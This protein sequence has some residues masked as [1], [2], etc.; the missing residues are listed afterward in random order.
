MRA[1]PVVLV[2]FDVR[3]NRS[4]LVGIMRDLYH[5]LPPHGLM[6]HH[7][8]D[9]FHTAGQGAINAEELIELIEFIGRHRILGA[10]EWFVL[11]DAGELRSGDTCIT[12]DDGLRCQYDVAA[13]VLRKYGIKAFFFVNT[14][15]S[16]S[17]GYRLEF[18]R[19]FRTVAFSKVDEFYRAFMAIVYS[20]EYGEKVRE[21]LC[22]FSPS[23]Y[24]KD[25]PFYTEGDRVFRYLRDDVLGPTSYFSL[26]DTMAASYGYVCDNAMKSRLWMGKEQLRNLSREGHIIGLHSHTHP[27]ALKRLSS[28]DQKFEYLCNSN[29]L[30]DILCK[31]PVCMS[32]PCNSYSD[33]TLDILRNLGIR[34]GFRANMVDGYG[35][36]LEY[37]RE[38]HANLLKEMKG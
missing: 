5:K 37:R 15:V 8:H 16:T 28:H 25:S 33:E 30:A 14:G 32:H 11:H 18:Y 17:D 24:L 34:L 12:F 4:V 35:S 13:P 10:E 20:S 29:A 36:G 2:K 26:M 23:D 6:F 7:F 1:D 21:A 3:T 38:D 19:Y 27:T 31:P 9:A 22:G